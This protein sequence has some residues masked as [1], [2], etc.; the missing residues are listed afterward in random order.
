MATETNKPELHELHE[1]LERAYQDS[2]LQPEI[3]SQDSWFTVETD[4]GDE[5]IPAGV[6]GHTGTARAFGVPFDAVRWSWAYGARLSASGYLD[7]TEWALFD[8]EREAVEY[9]LELAE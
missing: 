3:T 4:D 1:A 7:C 8:T 6:F 9:L 2:L 5:V